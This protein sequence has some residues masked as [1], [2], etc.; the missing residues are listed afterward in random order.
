MHAVI[1]AHCAAQQKLPNAGK[2]EQQGARRRNYNLVKHAG[3]GHADEEIRPDTTAFA[4]KIMPLCH[5]FVIRFLPLN[6]ITQY[7]NLR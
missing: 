1:A 2:L 6:H 5:A 7:K 3:S 4:Q